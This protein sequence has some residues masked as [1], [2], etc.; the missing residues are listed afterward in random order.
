MSSLN[1]G[2][3]SSWLTHNFII[4]A[5]TQKSL[6]SFVNVVFV[7][8]VSTPS[9]QQF[10]VTFIHFIPRLHKDIQSSD[11]IVHAGYVC[12]ML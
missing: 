3:I 5:N 9:A 7:S 4:I 10:V 1:N 12:V 11:V 6:E 2:M 8:F